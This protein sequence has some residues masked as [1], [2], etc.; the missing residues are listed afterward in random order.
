MTKFLLTILSFV[1]LSHL[2][3]CSPAGVLAS[4]GATTMVVAEGDRSLGTVVDDATI[5]I[6]LAAKFLQAD[7]EFFININSNVLEGRVLLTGIVEDQEIRIEAVRTAWEVDGVKEVINEIQ[8]GNKSNLK[9]YA[10][11]LWINTQA[12]S[13]AAKAIGLR[14][15]SY[16]FETIRGRVYI[17]GITRKPEQLNAII[18]STK[19]IKGVK[20][21]VNYVVV[22]E[23]KE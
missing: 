14:S 5:K 7:N 1:F 22:K 21:I 3:S 9:E 23:P 2:Y 16:N 17:A 19:T 15:F 12:K 11:D 18:E 8:V 10:N 4:G 6:N 20:E 13:L